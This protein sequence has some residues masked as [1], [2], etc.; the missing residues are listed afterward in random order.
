M[1]EV[2][3]DNQAWTTVKSVAKSAAGVDEHDVNATGR[4]LR[5]R[6]TQRAT[7]WGYSL[8]EFE[9]Y[10]PAG[11]LSQ[12]RPATVSSREGTSPFSLYWPLLMIGAGLPALLAPK[13]SGDQVFGLF[14]TGIGV[15]L[16][17]Q[18]LAVTTW[19]FSQTWPVLLTAAGLLLVVQALRQMTVRSDGDDSGSGGMQ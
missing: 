7:P 4:Y 2:S 6:G 16:Q 9:V 5:M 1:I 15:F 3:D 12:G 13:D 8:W 17:L 18:S 10:S 11:L 19:T 14:L